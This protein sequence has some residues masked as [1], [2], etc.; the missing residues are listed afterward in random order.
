[1]IFILPTDTCYG[2]AGAFTREDYEEIYRLKWRDFSKKLAFLIEDFSE[3]Q[4]YTEITDDQILF[5]KQYPYPWSFLGKR[6]SHFALPDFLKPAD[7][8]M[9]SLRVAEKCINAKIRNSIKY[10]LFL[11]SANLSWASESRTF[12][13]AREVF[14]WIHGV[15]G[16]VCDRPPSDIFSIGNDGMLK[17]LRKNY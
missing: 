14:P 13:E 3:L 11:T 5:L 7:Y 2:L 4:K 9:I 12:V 1:M 6:N 10:P 17:Y 8:A 15:D 16:W